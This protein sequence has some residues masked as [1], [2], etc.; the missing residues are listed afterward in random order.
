MQEALCPKIQDGAK[1][2]L[3]FSFILRISEDLFVPVTDVWELVRELGNA[4]LWQGMQ[5]ILVELARGFSGKYKEANLDY[6]R[7]IRSKHYNINKGA[8]FV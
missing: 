4:S 5:H 8:E 7:S 6:V 2:I 1:D 3:P